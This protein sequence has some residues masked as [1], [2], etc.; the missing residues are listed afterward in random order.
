[1]ISEST[2]LEFRLALR[3]R[4]PVIP[5]GMQANIPLTYPHS[6][7]H[8]IIR[9]GDLDRIP[10]Y[11]W[12]VDHSLPCHRCCRRSCGHLPKI[13]R[14]AHPPTRLL[15]LLHFELSAGRTPRGVRSPVCAQR[16]RN[17]WELRSD[18]QGATTGARPVVPCH[19]WATRLQNTAQERWP[20]LGI[21]IL[22]RMACQVRRQRHSTGS[23]GPRAVPEGQWG[24]LESV[25][26]SWHL[27]W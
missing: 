3:L 14:E 7:R 1:M 23:R 24:T 13:H 9:P 12:P 27:V 2:F 8:S 4:L 11:N 20:V 10:E 26:G 5:V 21:L 15:S 22:W 18:C 17:V 19:A 25:F 6:V 16:L